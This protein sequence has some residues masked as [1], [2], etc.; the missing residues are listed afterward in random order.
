[1]TETY[2]EL[3]VM[4]N[5]GPLP[6]HIVDEVFCAIE[7]VLNTVIGIGD[8]DFSSVLRRHDDGSKVLGLRGES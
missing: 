4:V 8:F 2:H 6:E 3:S 1:M 7:D 5:G